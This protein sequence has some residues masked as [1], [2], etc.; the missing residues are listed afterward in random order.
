MIVFEK[1]DPKEREC[2]T[3]EEIT[4][5]LEFKYLY[6]LRN[7][8]KIITHEFEEARVSAEAIS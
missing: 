3:E 6:V 7:S 8:A 1:C 2:K 5:W 4:K